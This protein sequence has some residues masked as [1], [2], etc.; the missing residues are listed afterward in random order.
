[1]RFLCRKIQR[2]IR[3]LEL[4]YYVHFAFLLWLK[5]DSTEGWIKHSKCQTRAIFRRHIN[6]NSEQFTVTDSC[7]GTAG[8]E[9]RSTWKLQEA[10][11]LYNFASTGSSVHTSIPGQ[12][13]SKTQ[14]S[15][16]SLGI[17]VDTVDSTPQ[18]CQAYTTL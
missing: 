1:M 10:L 3:A 8:Y 16:V 9:T 14:Y 17:Q 7:N 5:P 12:R 6:L 15:N 2:C 11:S 13:L 4:Q 18:H